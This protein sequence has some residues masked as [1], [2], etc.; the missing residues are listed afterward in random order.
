[1]PVYIS[2]KLRLSSES[3]FENSF[4]LIDWELSCLAFHTPLPIVVT[5]HLAFRAPMSHDFP[6][7]A[8]IQVD[9]SFSLL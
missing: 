3:Y 2:Q 5:G 7:Q 9:F 8:D 4:V 1:M 6:P